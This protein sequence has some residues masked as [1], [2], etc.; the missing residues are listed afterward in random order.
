MNW[1]KLEDQLPPKNTLV[2]V[3]RYPNK[4]EE[5]PI[6]FAM[7]E[8]KPLSV[9]PDASRDCYWHGSNQNTFLAEHEK[10]YMFDSLSCFSDVTVKE[11][12]FIKPICKNN[13]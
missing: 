4:I 3:K 13:K 6:Y 7:R 10:P 9:N 12:A 2:V 8:D 11:W 5:E 1:I